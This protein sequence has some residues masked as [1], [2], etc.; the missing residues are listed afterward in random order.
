MFTLIIA[1]KLLKACSCYDP[2]HLGFVIILSKRERKRGMSERWKK[3][4]RGKGRKGGEGKM[5][6][7]EYT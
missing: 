3:G 1:C 2:C 6:G 5:G 4:G 7:R